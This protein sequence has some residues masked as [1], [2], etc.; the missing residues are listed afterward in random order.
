MSSSVTS[1][2]DKSS[3]S[4]SLKN[5]SKSQSSAEEV[6]GFLSSLK[7]ALVG[8]DEPQVKAK[9]AEQGGKATPTSG[10]AEAVDVKADK[11]RSQSST[12]KDASSSGSTQITEALL[13]GPD[14]VTTDTSNKSSQPTGKEDV[15][16]T[17]TDSKTLNTG[18]GI[19]ELA[20][21]SEFEQTVSS[22]NASSGQ[23]SKSSAQQAMDEGNAL[24]G[25][26]EE[27]NQSL[28]PTKAQV[29]AEP[30]A[31]DPETGSQ[32]TTD[33]SGISAVAP[34]S[35]SL[36][37]G[38]L[39][40]GNV[41]SADVTPNQLVAE[42]AGE[43]TTQ[44]NQAQNNAKSEQYSH[45][46]WGNPSEPVQPLNVMNQ[47]SVTQ[48]GSLDIN[49]VA[50]TAT[51]GALMSSAQP[52]TDPQGML[53]EEEL[54]QL[55]EEEIAQLMNGQVVHA[56]PANAA[57]NQQIVAH[58]G[59]TVA[60]G[61][62]VAAALQANQAAPQAMSQ[63]ASVPTPNNE[64][65]A[66]QFNAALNPTQLAAAQSTSPNR[67]AA[68]LGAALGVGKLAAAGT[69][70]KSN[71]PEARLDQQL[72]GMA[73]QQGVNAN[74]VRA[75]AQQAAVNSPLVLNREMAG[76]Q[77]AERV[78]MMLAKNLKS[79]DI[80]L[81]PPELGR[82]QIRMTMNNDVASVQ[83]TVANQQSRD[84]VEQ[85]MPRLR[86]ML[87]QQ[88]VQLADTSVQQQNSG[89]QQQGQ[90]ASGSTGSGGGGTSGEDGSADNHDESVNLEMNIT[91]K[92]DGIS[93]YA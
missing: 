2:V 76:E 20:A 73:M 65:Q 49:P 24:L 9:A 91:E 7:S 5:N 84:M 32:K 18:S 52:N 45:I 26:L 53:P 81:D 93:F 39:A 50:S 82:M 44:G 28:R 64:G 43:L 14:G 78:Q 70:K 27:A 72:S 48:A 61:A 85:A 21:A 29:S 66:G 77:M 13:E 47:T 36:K 15:E 11:E 75:E 33:L 80:R 22:D 34:A 35:L 68:Q 54:A 1:S 25:K 12:T 92:G 16:L 30:V 83:F 63:H 56:Q 57:N 3:A 23:A 41:S 60:S 19:S 59:S 86:E 17:A 42:Q 79:V 89:Q 58:S 71:Q 40:D 88:G 6:E 4:I 51:A 46:E 31:A 8:S 87:A 69:D 10:N 74:Q 38:Q 37:E 62:A 67:Q 55:S 90:M